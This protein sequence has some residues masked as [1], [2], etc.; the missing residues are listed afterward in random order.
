MLNMIVMGGGIAGCTAAFELAQ[1]GV[2]VTIIEKTSRIGGKVKDYG[3][4]ATDKCNNCGTC[5]VGGL[6]EKVEKNPYID[7]LYNSKVVDVTGEAGDFSVVA[8]TPEGFRY[9]NGI[10]SIVVA[11]GF[12]ESPAPGGHL[13]IGSGA[14][15]IIRGLQLESICKGRSKSAI[16]EKAPRSVAFIQCAGSRDKKEGALYCSKVC[17]GYSTRAAMV[18]R[19][20][21]PDCEIV[22]FYMELQSVSS[23]DY[24][25]QLK[26]KNIEFVKCR[27]L[28]VKA[29]APAKVVYETPDGGEL[30]E[31]EFDLVVL[32][33]GIHPTKDADRLA[34]ICGLAQDSFGFL[35]SIG[36]G[37]GG[38][39]GN[40]GVGGSGVYV[41]GCARQ[42]C[43]IADTYSDAVAVARQ[44]LFAL[45]F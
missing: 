30:V 3:C 5:L 37:D 22:F 23:G 2:K 24:F 10:A 43:T 9:I 7:I 35:S 18:I 42:P 17:C 38:D 33:E 28:K 11:T 19:Q 21:Y 29:G 27:P 14:Q 44:A 1:N 26:D 6:W 12:E 13:Q 15:G 32:S 39:G 20:T 40:G 31:R 36:A 25:A 4:M 41:A 16:F 45:P 8:A 34:E